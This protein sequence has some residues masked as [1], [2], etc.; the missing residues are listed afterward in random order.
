MC[1][2]TACLLPGMAWHGMAC[3]D[4][5]FGAKWQK[6][7]AHLVICLCA[8]G[9]MR[10]I[11]SASSLLDECILV[12]QSPLNKQRLDMSLCLRRRFEIFVFE[13]EAVCSGWNTVRPT[14]RPYVS[15]QGQSDGTSGPNILSTRL[16][17]SSDSEAAFL[18]QPV[19]WFS[20]KCSM[21][22]LLMTAQSEHRLQQLSQ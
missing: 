19:W 21:T 14:L 13:I 22:S 8:I 7:V 12:W 17:I 2:P 16:H 11:G 9:W 18:G 20:S 10:T 3:F 1:M 4:L 15:L 6:R 5:R